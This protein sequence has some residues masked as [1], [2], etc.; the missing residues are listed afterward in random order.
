[1]TR[2]SLKHRT[3]DLFEIDTEGRFVF[4][5]PLDVSDHVFY[6]VSF[7]V[8][9]PVKIEG[10]TSAEIVAV[11]PDGETRVISR[12]FI[13]REEEMMATT[14]GIIMKPR[15]AFRESMTGLQLFRMKLTSLKILLSVDASWMGECP[16]VKCGVSS[17]SLHPTELQA[18]K[19][20]GERF[21]VTVEDINLVQGS[22]GFIIPSGSTVKS[23]RWSPTELP[24]TLSIPR[25]VTNF[26]T[27]LLMYDNEYSC[28][29]RSVSGLDRVGNTF[30]SGLKDMI[31]SVPGTSLM[32][33]TVV[34]MWEVGDRVGGGA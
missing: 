20:D 15:W 22:E 24:T 16:P 19:D 8:D 17:C 13:T 4:N 14:S 11:M 18:H 1:M 29:V 7:V 30:F 5:V 23:I 2:Y 6:D 31:V 33:A 32:I 25:L 10:T 26:D 21:L 28:D 12:R 9:G 27:R 34:K 3:V